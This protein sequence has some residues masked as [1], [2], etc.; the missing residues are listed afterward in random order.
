MRKLRAV[1]RS[2]LIMEVELVPLLWTCVGD[3]ALVILEREKPVN[4]RDVLLTFEKAQDPKSQATVKWRDF[5]RDRKEG[6]YQTV[7]SLQAAALDVRISN[8]EVLL[9]KLRGLLNEQGSALLLDC[10]GLEEAKRK[11][12]KIDQQLKAAELDALVGPA[13]V[14]MVAAVGGGRG[15]GAK[16]WG[17]CF[18]C[19][20]VGHNIADCKARKSG[21]SRA[22]EGWRG[23]PRLSH[24]YDRATKVRPVNTP[25]MGS[26]SDVAAADAIMSAVALKAISGRRS[27]IKVAIAIGSWRVEA[28]V[29]T[30]AGAMVVDY[31]AFADAVQRKDI[32]VGKENLRVAKIGDTTEDAQGNRMTMKYIW[33]CTLA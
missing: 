3:R 25:A 29:D 32:A 6:W 16:N 30:E 8:Q 2:T 9:N 11:L 15:R 31:V 27:A 19:T 10:E 22:P 17:G 21:A 14:A 26:T 7:C 28:L 18:W 24:A 23:P 1:V 20:K 13:K 33:T 5:R 12:G 4:L